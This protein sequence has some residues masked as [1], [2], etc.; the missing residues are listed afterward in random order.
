MIQIWSKGKI[1]HKDYIGR[2]HLFF[3][4]FIEEIAFYEFVLSV[5]FAPPTHQSPKMPIHVLHVNNK[6][7]KLKIRIW[8]VKIFIIKV[9]FGKLTSA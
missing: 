1:V 2:K 4:Y 9:K 3:M 6:K 7:E 8:E 5:T